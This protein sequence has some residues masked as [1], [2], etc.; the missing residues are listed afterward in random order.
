[1]SLRSRLIRM[2][3]L[4]GY[5]AFNMP[6]TVTAAGVALLLGCV[7]THIYAVLSQPDRPAFFL[8]YVAAAVTGCGLIAVLLCLTRSPVAMQL[9]WVLGSAA[10]VVIAGI[11]AGTRI[12]RLSALPA[13]TGRWDVAAATLTLAFA[14]AFVALHATVLLGINVAYPRRQHWMD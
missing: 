13:I 14:G 6:R 7:A 2:L 11:V 8:V 1:M 4:G 3:S 9:S 12:V 5:V 10:S